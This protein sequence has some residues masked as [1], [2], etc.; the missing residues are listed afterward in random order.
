MQ[1]NVQLQNEIPIPVAMFNYAVVVPSKWVASNTLVKVSKPLFSY[2]LQICDG[3]DL[4]ISWTVGVHMHPLYLSTM[5]MNSH[6]G[7]KR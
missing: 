4:N 3:S 7:L 6:L 5:P 1:R 2:V